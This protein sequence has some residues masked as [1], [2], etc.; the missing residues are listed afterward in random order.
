MIK[1]RNFLK[2][3]TIFRLLLLIGVIVISNIVIFGQLAFIPGFK[4]N[5]LV[6]LILVIMIF[7]TGI[8]YWKMKKRWIALII[9]LF[10]LVLLITNTL[11]F[12]RFL[13]YLPR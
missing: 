3:L 1:I 8:E 9:F 4:L 6:Q 13:Q 10:A 11:T 7:T 12:M 2:P 5:M